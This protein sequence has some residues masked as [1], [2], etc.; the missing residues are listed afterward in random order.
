M[1]VLSHRA[2]ASPEPDPD[3]GPNR[4]AAAMVLVLALF[5]VAAVTWASLAELDVA[6]Q[7]RGT[8]VPPSRLQELQSLEGGLLEALLVAPGALV[9]KGQVLA[10]LDTTQ[11][12]ADLGESRQQEL[13]ALATRARFDALLSGRAP[14]FEAAW[15]AE[16]PALIDKEGQLYRDSQREYSSNQSALREGVLRRRGELAE[17]QGRLASLRATLAV[18]EQSFAIEERLFREGAGARADYLAAQQR[19]MQQRTEIDTLQQSLPRLQA[20]LAET[21]AQAAEADARARAQWG[22]ARSEAETKAATLA[23]G[24]VAKR[25]RVARRELVSPMDGVVNRI[26]INTV[27]GVVPPGKP[28]MEIV[29]IED[30][31]L[32]SARIKPADIG[33]VRLGQQAHVRVLPYDAATYGQIDAVVERVGADAVLDEKGEAYF[34]VQ[35]SAAREQLKLHGQPL[36]IHTGMPVDVGI[37][38]GQRSV[39]QYLFK[40]VL[41][42]VQGALQER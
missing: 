1:A 3:G 15:R 11:S 40:P 2:L 28:V 39:L 30:K 31:L 9:K 22:A 33:F 19:L 6:T 17:A 35:L 27:G 4:V 24:L 13:A 5:V 36:P 38:T 34:E 26:L 7:G 29:P 25:D 21:Q 42:S 23:A 8:V 18:A 16:A 20:G 41:R 12:D 10:R 14:Q 32:L 37:L